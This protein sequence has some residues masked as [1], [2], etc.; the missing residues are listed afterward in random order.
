MAELKISIRR[1]NSKLDHTF[2]IARQGKNEE[3]FPIK[4][5]VARRVGLFYLLIFNGINDEKFYI[6]C[7]YVILIHKYTYF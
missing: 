1:Q 5:L 2:Q 6:K 7:K 4:C 3:D